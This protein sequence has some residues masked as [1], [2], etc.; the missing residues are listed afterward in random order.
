MTV[1][2]PGD[3]HIEVIDPQARRK[4][5]TG[6]LL[7]LLGCII[8]FARWRSDFQTDY[9][10]LIF[11]FLIAGGL[12]HN[13]AFSARQIYQVPHRFFFIVIAVGLSLFPPFNILCVP[14]LILALI[15]RR[16]NAKPSVLFSEKGVTISGWRKLFYEW[17]SFESVVLKDDLLTLD[18]TNNR[19]LQKEIVP[20]SPVD[21]SDFNDWVSKQIAK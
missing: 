2:G 11:A 10:D 18:F 17:N 9:A 15:E 3:Y 8:F 16:F 7:S 1:E 13:F 19:L 5:I 14:Y 20:G 6:I 4:L 21:E 12:I